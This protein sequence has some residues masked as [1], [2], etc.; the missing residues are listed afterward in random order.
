MNLMLVLQAFIVAVVGGIIYSFIGLIP[1]TDETATMAPITLILVLLGF[2][3]VVLFAW[4]IGIS[5]SMH[6]THT[7]PT[8][9][10]GLP[11]STM[12]V[13]MVNQCLTAKR[14]G[15]PHVSMRKMAAGSLVGA[16]V[17]VPVSV[18]FAMLLA[19]LGQ[20]ITP[21]IGII[22]TL[23][24]IFLAYMSSAKFGA[25]LAL[26]P[27]AFMIQGMQLIAAKGVN[28]TL[29]ISIFMGITIGPMISEIFNV[30]IPKI[31]NNQMREKESELWLAPDS[32]NK[33]GLFPN[34]LKI[35][36]R[37][38]A[39][40]AAL[41]GAIAA[42]TFTFSPVGMTVLLGELLGNR[43]KGIYNKLF[44]SLSVKSAVSNATYIGEL[45]IPLVAFGLPLSPVSLGPAGPLFNAP[46]R[47]TVDPINNLHSF[48]EPYQFVIFGII[49]V[50]G[51]VLFGYPVSIRYARKWTESIFKSISHEALIGAFLGL[52]VMLA[53]YEAGILGI[54]IA[55]T[56]GLFG[57][58][59]HN[60]FGVHTGIQFMAYY[61]SSWILT[62]ILNVIK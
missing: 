46:P 17:A 60:L 23:A 12:A 53:Y 11:G 41:G 3:P 35:L 33:M 52:V 24:A 29:F 26:V 51:G 20:Y 62:S 34:P 15:A 30:F 42:C 37:R 2:H 44:T 47:F 45:I 58:I 13:P 59:M 55:V 36:T 5:V 14:L 57:G 43:R 49:G 21:Y 28:K 18:G 6:I 9:M 40:N 8:A 50:I 54:L 16:C 39:S 61:A 19:P 48:V 38:Q 31:K 22:F 25:I 32:G 7:I 4:F 10:A 1:G 27:F 56:I